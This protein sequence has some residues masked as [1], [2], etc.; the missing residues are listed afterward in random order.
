MSDVLAELGRSGC[1][2]DPDTFA[3]LDWWPGWQPQVALLPMGDEA[4]VRLAYGPD[5]HEAI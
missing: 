2:D 1:G 3:G 5:Q 4:G